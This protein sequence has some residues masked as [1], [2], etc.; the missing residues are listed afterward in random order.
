[1]KSQSIKVIRNQSGQ[2]AIATILL[3]VTFLILG[4]IAIDIGNI[5]FHKARL[6]RALDAS[7]I[8]GLK[9]YARKTT[10]NAGVEAATRQMLQYNLNQM[11]VSTGEITQNTA[12]LT[13]SATEV[14][15]LE[16]VGTV[17]I[18]TVFVRLA[19]FPTV[20]I[21]GRASG[22]R[23][24]AAVSLVLDVSDSMNYPTGTPPLAALKK[25]AKIFVLSFDEMDRMGIVT[26]DSVASE[27]LSMQ[28]INKNTIKTIIDALTAQA[29]T[30][31]ADGIILGGTEF[32]TSLIDNPD[33]LKALVLFSD[34]A[35]TVIRPRFTNAN[36]AVLTPN[37]GSYYQ[38][39]AQSTINAFGTQ[40]RLM[41]PPDNIIPPVPSYYFTCKDTS[42]LDKFPSCFNTYTYLDSQGV[43]HN[44]V[45]TI[46]RTS[47]QVIREPYHLAITE[48]DYVRN[49]DITIYA[50]GLGDL[51]FPTSDAYQGY[52]IDETVKSVLLRRIANDPA[53]ASDP[54]FTPPHP[55]PGTS[56][57]E[58]LFFE[59]P[60]ANELI[61]LFVKVAKNIQARLIE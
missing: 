42:T 18:N 46:S 11:G 51:S 29:Q 59:T 10:N 7:I 37:S 25:A 22:Q 55:R 45:T 41:L 27:K 26:F 34:G 19:G 17:R 23:K 44:S 52:N 61:S 48:S 58:G 9:V 5:F 53:G 13:I 24:P 49:N 43:T 30:A 47:F 2:I 32:T 20:N 4:G 60:D 35:P 1:M 15:T 21:S 56:K 38:Y 50:V 40:F 8:A 33:M 36:S 28:Y 57:P 39:I 12:T 14:A 54:A 31:I 16:A 6:Q 3:T